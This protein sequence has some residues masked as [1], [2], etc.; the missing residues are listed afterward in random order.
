[1]RRPT[2]ELLDAVD[3]NGRPLSG[4]TVPSRNSIVAIK[5]EPSDGEVD[6]WKELPSITVPGEGAEATSPLSKKSNAL[7]SISGNRNEA[8]MN[9]AKG[10]KNGEERQSQR[11]V[12]SA[13]AAAISTLIQNNAS[14]RQSIANSAAKEREPS[15]PSSRTAKDTE[16]KDEESMAVF[17]FVSSSPPRGTHPS[18]ESIRARGSRRHSSIS[19]L[20]NMAAAKEKEKEEKGET[21]PASRNASH[22]RQSSVNGSTSISAAAPRATTTTT[23]T[24]SARDGEDTEGA[25]LARSERLAARRRSSTMML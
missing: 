24:N 8:E 6:G 12:Q 23:T 13:A 11:P 9:G 5:T 15:A 14:R 1:M 10:R 20:A 17:D 19:N 3:R 22:K 25:G 16:K 4:I 7:K 21:R 18:V 2:K